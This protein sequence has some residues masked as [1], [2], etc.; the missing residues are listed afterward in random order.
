MIEFYWNEPYDNGGTSITQYELSIFRVS[1]SSVQTVIVINANRYIY[2]SAA[3]GFMAG[4]E[5]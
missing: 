1:D 4:R 2:S 3:L 5:Y